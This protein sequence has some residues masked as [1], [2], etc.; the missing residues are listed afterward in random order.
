[1]SNS[2]SMKHL[3]QT[4][5]YY[6]HGISLTPIQTHLVSGSTGLAKFLL[7]HMREDAI[8]LQF[9]NDFSLERALSICIDSKDPD[10]LF[11]I[12]AAVQPKNFSGNVIGTIVWKM[13]R[14]PDFQGSPFDRFWNEMVV[15]GK[16]TPHMFA[17]EPHAV[18]NFID[19]RAAAKLIPRFESLVPIMRDQVGALTGE[20]LEF[21]LRSFTEFLIRAT[22]KAISPSLE[23]CLNLVLHTI[24]IA[25]S[26]GVCTTVFMIKNALPSYLESWHV[27]AFAGKIIRTAAKADF[28]IA[29]ASF[30]E[31]STKEIATFLLS[32]SSFLSDMKVVAPL[33]EDILQS[34]PPAMLKL[35]LAENDSR[36]VGEALAA[37]PQLKPL[38]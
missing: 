20:S 19:P 7:D 8:L 29:N 28:D 17:Y 33:I 13:L 37:S 3:T 31:S 34:I 6:N 22:K 16:R 18:L 1:M 38:L 36:T 26:Q 35:P 27:S 30:H 2:E 9:P 4:K 25:A 10:L 11:R 24:G 32:S 23:I 21:F 12:I 15:S 5:P 14:T